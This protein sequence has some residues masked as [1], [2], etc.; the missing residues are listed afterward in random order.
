MTFLLG[1]GFVYSI[2]RI[3]LRTCQ[4]THTITN[5]LLHYYWYERLG[6]ARVR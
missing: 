1:F 2:L 5:L 3:Q 6:R 4:E